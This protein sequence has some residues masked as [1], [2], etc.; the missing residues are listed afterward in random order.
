MW[1][2]L[3]LPESDSTRLKAIAGQRVVSVRAAS[4]RFKETGTATGS[5]PSAGKALRDE[6]HLH[7]NILLVPARVFGHFS[8]ENG[9]FHDAVRMRFIAERMIPAIISR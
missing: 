4:S 2:S 3:P 5:W 9:D 7:E 6:I 1:M 8:M